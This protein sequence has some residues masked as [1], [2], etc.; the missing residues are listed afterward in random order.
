[1]IETP[2][3]IGDTLYAPR[4]QAEKKTIPCPVC[5]GSGIVVVLY[6]GEERL[7]LECEAC[8][9]GYQNSYGT[10][11]EWDLTPAVTK[12]VIAS[13]QSMHDGEYTLKSE[14]GST[15]AF[16]LLHATQASALEA[17]EKACAER[18]EQNMR[19]HMS[20]MSRV[21]RVSWTAQYHKKCIAD[22]EKQ[23]AWHVSKINEKS[24]KEQQL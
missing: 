24:K 17:S 8:R 15:Y 13:V 10:I 9:I 16:H 5:N 23:I 20:S 18:H 6:G 11:D 2:F 22:H 1:M 21:K 19:S 12:F 3:Q 7:S 14:D 4:T